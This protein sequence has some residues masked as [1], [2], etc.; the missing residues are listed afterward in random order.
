MGDRVQ[1]FD[2]PHE[3]AKPSFWQHLVLPLLDDFTCKLA[4]GLSLDRPLDTSIGSGTQNFSNVEL[5][6]YALI[7]YNAVEF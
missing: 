5:P 6:R 7:T 1:Q 4:S 3:L 2:F